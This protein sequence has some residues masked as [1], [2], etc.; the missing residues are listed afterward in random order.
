MT[1]Q[2]RSA[3]PAGPT[4]STLALSRRRD[5]LGD[6]QLLLDAHGESKISVQDHAVAMVDELEH[7]QHERSLFNVAY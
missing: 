5:G 3:D 1:C 4:R 2:P 7:P 6:G